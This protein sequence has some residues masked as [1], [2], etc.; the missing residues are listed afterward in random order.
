MGKKFFILKKKWLCKECRLTF[1]SI[2]ARCP[3]CSSSKLLRRYKFKKNWKCRSCKR[4]YKSYLGVC[5]E[6]A[7]ANSKRTL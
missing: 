3:R 5:P 1:E 2:I 6:C 7:S 4:R